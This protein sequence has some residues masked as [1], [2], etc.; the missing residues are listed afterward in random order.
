MEPNALRQNPFEPLCE[1][2]LDLCAKESER[3]FPEQSIAALS[4]AGVWRHSIDPKF[5]GI[6]GGLH[7]QF[8]AYHAI[9]RASLPVALILTQHDAACELLGDSEN[10][11]LAAK[12]LPRCASGNMLLTVG[13]SQLTTSRRRGPAAMRAEPVDAGFRVTGA[14][15]WVTS[16]EKADA[17]VVGAA[18]EDDT[19]ILGLLDADA[20]GVKIDAP[21]ELLALRSSFTAEVRCEDVLLPHERLLRGPAGNV[22]SRRS[23]IKPLTVSVV[24]LGVARALLDEVLA[25]S[26]S[27]PDCAELLEKTVE[28]SYVSVEDKLLEA[29]ERLR[30]PA[31]EVSGAII[32]SEV[33]ALIAKLSAT[34][35]T[36][37]KGSGFALEHPAQRLVRE[38]LFF[39]VWSA[40]S[41]VQRRTL[42]K[43]WN[44]PPP[45]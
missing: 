45:P 9:G 39:L 8:E 23:T 13:I 18:L 4:E 1:R 3:D 21:I 10:H 6:R 17:I 24:G 5:G 43:I 36:A 22:L 16:A 37:A 25:R 42:E 34:L 12:V 27:I 32:R 44:A 40:P 26:S 2:L 38:G 14:M 30:D 15:P 31:E 19:Q 33:N 35:L 11:S 29:A 28:P 41:A 20:P 7:P